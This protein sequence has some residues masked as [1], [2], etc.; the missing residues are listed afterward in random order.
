[1]V[2]FVSRHLLARSRPLGRAEGL[3]GFAIQFPVKAPSGPTEVPWEWD[4]AVR[5]LD[6]AAGQVN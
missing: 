5:S 2:C 4:M 6:K 3:G 1:M